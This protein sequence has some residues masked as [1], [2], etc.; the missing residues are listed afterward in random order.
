[1]NENISSN[2]ISSNLTCELIEE[3]YKIGVDTFGIADL[4]Y[5]NEYDTYPKD[6]FENYSRGISIGLKIP[7]EVLERLPESR[8]IYAKHYIMIND[9]LDFIAY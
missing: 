4:R 5:L 1:M 7:N 9:R 6:L 2:E 8:P 3:A